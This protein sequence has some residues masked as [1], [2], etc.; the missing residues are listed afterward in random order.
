MKITVKVWPNAG[1]EKIEKI[2]DGNFK[3]YVREPPIRGEANKAVSRV[4]AEY[5]SVSQMEVRLVSGFS[6]RHKIFK[7]K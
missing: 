2:S 7:I 4:L 6:S 1:V 3:I 5:F